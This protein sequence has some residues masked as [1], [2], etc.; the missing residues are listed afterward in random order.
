[1]QLVN[2]SPSGG[3]SVEFDRCA[4]VLISGVSVKVRYFESAA[5]FRAWLETN[6]AEAA[7]LWVGFYKKDSGK[8]GITY[9]EALDEALCFGWIDGIRKRV[10]E[11]SYTNR[12]TPRRL[13]SVWS[14]VNTRRVEQLRA[15]GRMAEAGLKA[16]VARDT[17]RS[18]IYSFEKE[19]ALDARVEKRFKRNKKAWAF[20][21]RQ[22]PGYRRLMKHR[23]MS[24]KRE[25]TRNR[26]L[27]QLIAVS[28]RGLRMNLLTGKTADTLTVS[29]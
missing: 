16:F 18:G 23:V 13:R 27:E 25:D 19:I 12:F 2:T 5:E 29:P 15:L 24:A 9:A 21:Q 17:R 6:H 1:M 8:G 22:P 11:V 4:D 20:F 28:A 26:R 14:I 3:D 10:D 7:E